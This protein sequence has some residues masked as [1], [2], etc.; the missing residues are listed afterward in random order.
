MVFRQAQHG[1]AV[2]LDGLDRHEVLRVELVR[3]V[4]QR[5]VAVPRL[6][7]FAQRR[8]GGVALREVEL[9]RLLVAAPRLDVG[10]EAA[11]VERPAHRLFQRGA[12]GG[13]VEAGRV[14]VGAHRLALHE[15]ALAGVDRVEAGGARGDVGHLASD[16]EQLRHERADRRA[17]RH[18]ELPLGLRVERL[19][20]GAGGQQP[21]MQVGRVRLQRR[22]EAPVE[23]D[24]PV[25]GG[26]V[27]E[28]RAEAEGGCVHGNPVCRRGFAAPH[29]KDTA[30]QTSRRGTTRPAWVRSPRTGLAAACPR[31]LAMP[32]LATQ[33]AD[34][35]RCCA[36]ARDDAVGRCTQLELRGLTK[37]YGAH[38]AVD[39]VSLEVAGGEFLTLLGPSGSGKTTL[40][41]MVAGFTAPS[42]GDVLADGRAIT[43]MPPERR[44]FGMV[45]QGY[46]LFP[47]MT[48]AGNV[49]YPLRVRGV[50]R[51]E[52]ARRVREALSLVRLANLDDRLPRHLSGGQQQRVAIARALVFG[53][54]L[55]LLDE[56]LGALDR[57]LRA[58]VQVELKALHAALGTTFVYVTHDQDEALSMSDRIAIVHH[59]R[60]EQVGAPAALYEQPRTRFAAEFLGSSNCLVAEPRDRQGELQRLEVGGRS[61][62]HRGP[63]P[64]RRAV[65]AIRPERITLAHAEPDTANRAPGRVRDVAY[66]G[67]TLQASIR[68]E[69]FG[70]LAVRC[71]AWGAPTLE[72][73]A[74]VWVGWAPEATTL[75]ADEP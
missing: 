20:F 53:P 63:V 4:E 8:P 25:A 31:T 49:A 51:A 71:M 18:D 66:L 36:S 32:H 64:N 5:A 72:P 39:D 57:Q 69:A 37:S 34:A 12:Q 9:A 68:T 40:L 16:A 43:A 52:T 17:E 50:G 62:L 26:E 60:L 58:E 21:D 42:A 10:G 29:T 2:A 19:G 33:D 14:G 73:G 75:L 74:P 15:Q 55:L 27:G 54:G 35:S 46:A 23:P 56:P 22:Q 48:V 24:Q 61:I 59:G 1:N 70:T 67:A 7:G 44:N 65:L 41:M 45:F 28:G 47:H 30:G 13:G 11:L 6:A 3:H 38:R